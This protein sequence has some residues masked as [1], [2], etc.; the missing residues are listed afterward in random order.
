MASEWFL[1]LGIRLQE[2]D[3]F[4]TWIVITGALA[5]MACALPGC[6]LV[7]RRLSM[8]G[9]AISHSALPGIVLAFVLAQFLQRQSGLEESFQD[10]WRH[11]L[12]FSGA[13]V[14]GIAC[15][16]LT[17]WVQIHGQ[18]EA[19]AALGVVF[20]SLFALGLL[21]IRLL[22][23]DIDLDPDCVLYGTLENVVLDV[24]GGGLPKGALVNGL[25]LGGNLLFVGL[26][27]KELQVSSFDPALASAMGI[28]AR[29]MHYLLMTSTAVT[30]V[31][32][33]E[34]VGSILV[35]A[36]LIVPPATAS[37]L[38]NRLGW[39]I[40]ISL[41]LAASS[42]VLGHLMAI[43]IPPLIFRPLGYST[44]VDAGTAGMM[45][46]AAGLM[47]LAAMFFAPR[48]GLVS[49]ALQRWRLSLRM[50][51]EDLLGQLY[52]AEEQARE[53]AREQTG[54]EAREQT[55]RQAGEVRSEKARGEL[56][57]A[58]EREPRGMADD[59]SSMG[60]PSVVAWPGTCHGR[61]AV[62]RLRWMGFIRRQAGTWELTSAGRQVAQ[63]IVRSHRLWESYLARHFSIED[64]QL[65]E[66]AERAEHF[67]DQW[68]RGEL[69]VELDLPDRDPHGSVIPP[70]EAPGPS[71]DPR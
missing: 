27:F 56:S 34:S 21:L 43:T 71:P 49:R 33:F 25:V 36:M 2:W 42:A 65:H 60:P 58:S 35:I 39:M 10:L 48:Q 28:P 3:A 18:V 6:F 9:D 68:L 52:R 38:T 15:A 62:A 69:S 57:T 40:G 53:Q 47:F 1:Q 12:L 51:G 59:S 29:R 45:A 26:L 66:S 31:A 17:S 7:V 30:L 46:T 13:M 8:M 67:I 54:A 41:L 24:V 11:G 16:L 32:A 64:P 23:D 70:E 44:I 55:C 20:T 37:L 5:A 61:L 50:A 22:A 14:L 19:N 4:D 63:R